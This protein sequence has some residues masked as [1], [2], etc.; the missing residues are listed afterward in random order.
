MYSGRQVTSN[1]PGYRPNVASVE[2]AVRPTR[3]PSNGRNGRGTG[4]K[5]GVMTLRL[6][7]VRRMTRFRRANRGNYKGSSKRRIPAS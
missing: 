2:G 1:N 4:K 5:N 3:G 7:M 6:S